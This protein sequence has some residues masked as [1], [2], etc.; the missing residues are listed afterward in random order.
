MDD[1]AQMMADLGLERRDVVS[2]PLADSKGRAICEDPREQAAALNNVVAR[3]R[4][5]VGGG[6]AEG[7]EHA[8]RLHAWNS[9]P[10]IT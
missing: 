8:S 9:K 2:A 7:D 10:L 4:R 5:H 1:A 3:C 6:T